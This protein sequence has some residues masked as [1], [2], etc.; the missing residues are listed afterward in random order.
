[1]QKEEEGPSS[2]GDM[3]VECCYKGVIVFSLNNWD[4]TGIVNSDVWGNDVIMQCYCI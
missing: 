3:R 4:Q 2:F 1:V